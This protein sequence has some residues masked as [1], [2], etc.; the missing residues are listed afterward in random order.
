MLCSSDFNIRDGRINDVKRHIEL[1]KYVDSLKASASSKKNTSFSF[2]GSSSDIEEENMEAELLFSVF[3]CVQN[4]PAVLC[5]VSLFVN[6][7][8]Q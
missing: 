6:T 1:K 3:I 2:F 8:C 7:T 5:C 4:L